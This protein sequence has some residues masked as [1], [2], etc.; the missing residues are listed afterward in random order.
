MEF[1]NKMIFSADLNFRI[2]SVCKSYEGEELHIVGSAKEDERCAN[3]F[4][5]NLWIH[6]IL[7]SYEN[8]KFP[9]GLSLRV[10]QISK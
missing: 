9:L 10:N 5:R 4:V 3:V 7:L 8:R 2:E 1:P 6:R